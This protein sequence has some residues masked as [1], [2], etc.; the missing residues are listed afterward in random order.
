VYEKQV[1]AI[2]LPL[3]F[4]A[5]SIE[6]ASI[7][8]ACMLLTCLLIRVEGGSVPQLELDASHSLV[9][10]NWCRAE[11]EQKWNLLCFRN[12]HVMELPA[13][14]EEPCRCIESVG[15]MIDAMDE[16]GCLDVGGGESRGFTVAQALCRAVSRTEY[17]QLRTAKQFCT[18]AA[19]STF[20]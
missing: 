19:I 6:I 12:V 10:S 14:Q 3:K 7:A 9:E 8:Q 20:G 2:L 13:D 11:K 4:Y 16:A 15:T 17:Y 1:R 5:A 18:F